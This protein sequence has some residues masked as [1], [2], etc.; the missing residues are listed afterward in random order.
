MLE[1]TVRSFKMCIAVLL[2]NNLIPHRSL[3]NTSDGIRWSIDLRWQLPELSNGFYGLKDNIVMRVPGE[4]GYKIDW[5]AWSKVDRL[6]LGE[7]AVKADKQVMAELDATMETAAAAAAGG[8]DGE[9]KADEEFSTVIVGPWMKRWK[10][11][12]HN[13]H[14]DAF[15]ASEASGDAGTSWH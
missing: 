11:V 12:N 7:D 13:R 8:D 2:L 6:K 10:M 3:P 5:E 15:E 14:T 9:S 4:P 1:G